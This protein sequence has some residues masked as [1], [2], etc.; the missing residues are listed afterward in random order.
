MAKPK[1]PDGMRV[2]MCVKFSEPQAAVIDAARG[3]QDR[4]EWLR[5][6][7]LAAAGYQLVPAAHASMGAPRQDSATAG[8]KPGQRAAV[9][10]PRPVAAAMRASAEVPCKHPTA[11]INE[12]GICTECG[13]EL[14]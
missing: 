8:P 1:T 11:S 4:S 14:D 13:T 10:T 6:T 12:L 7:A 2:T 5:L 9:Q 3:H